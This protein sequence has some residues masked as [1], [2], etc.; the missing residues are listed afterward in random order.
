[1]QRNGLYTQYCAHLYSTK[2]VLR[3][4]ALLESNLLGR[5]EV[6]IRQHERIHLEK[7]RLE[8]IL[9]EKTEEHDRLKETL[10]SQIGPVDEAVANTQSRLATCESEVET[11]KAKCSQL[12]TAIEEQGMQVS[13]ERNTVITVGR[14]M[15]EMFE[16]AQEEIKDLQSKLENQEREDK[17]GLCS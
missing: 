8:E 14:N 13:G 11:L 6:S 17:K 5:Y 12:E 1:M 16:K 7:D 4:T 15:L 3:E 2:P 10:K 9:K